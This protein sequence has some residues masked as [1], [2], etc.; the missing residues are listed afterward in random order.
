MQSKT[1]ATLFLLLAPA[2]AKPQATSVA[3]DSSGFES[4]GSESSGSDS[5]DTT[6]ITS[7]PSI[8][9]D[10]VSVLETAVPTAWEYEMM[11]SASAAAVMSAAAEGIY[12]AWYNDLPASI[13]ALVTSLGGF[14]EVMV[15][16]TSSMTVAMSTSSIGPSS[17]A[18]MATT[19]VSSSGSTATETQVSAASSI[20]SSAKSSSPASTSST[21]GAPAATGGI[22]MGVA[23]AAGLLGLALAL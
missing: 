15:G 17:G 14:D 9:S 22:T 18:S 11:N 20:A 7:I 23:G 10:Y 21:G 6:D 4:S 12:P 1:L 13:K 3:S 19:V 2:L 8:P 16:E 5:L